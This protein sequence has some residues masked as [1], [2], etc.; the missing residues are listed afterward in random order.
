MSKSRT[1]CGLTPGQMLPARMSRKEC[2][3]IMEMHEEYCPRC[4]KAR[5][6]N[7]KRLVRRCMR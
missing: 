4:K 3:E 5:E 7:W 1:D 6:E 2:A